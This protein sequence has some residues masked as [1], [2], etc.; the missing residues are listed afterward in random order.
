MLHCVNL[1][2]AFLPTWA[3][4]ARNDDALVQCCHTQLGF[5]G[6]LGFVDNIPKNLLFLKQLVLVQGLLLVE[7]VVVLLL[8]LFQLIQSPLQRPTL[9]TKM[10]ECKCG[11]LNKKRAQTC[12]M[13]KLPLQRM[14]LKRHINVASKIGL[15]T[16]CV[17]LFSSMP[18]FGP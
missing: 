10:K 2:D 4:S 13:V 11:K 5:F 17:K 9:I 14:C 18:G 1:T 7:V 3:L 12:K 16:R 15:H 8:V 6:H